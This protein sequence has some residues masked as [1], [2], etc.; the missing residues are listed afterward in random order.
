MH[1]IYVTDTA[2]CPLKRCG[3]I[4]AYLFNIR[5]SVHRKKIPIYRVIQEESALLW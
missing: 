5:G 4:G 3:K 1:E 2:K